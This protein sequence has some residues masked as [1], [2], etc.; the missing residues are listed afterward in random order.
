MGTNAMQKITKAKYLFRGIEMET[1]FAYFN[2]PELISQGINNKQ[3][4][5]K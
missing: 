1:K 4:E 3:Y 5:N 2:I